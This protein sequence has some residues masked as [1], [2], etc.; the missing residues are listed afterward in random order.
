MRIIITEIEN[1]KNNI[2][3]NCNTNIG[4]LKGIWRGR[5]APFL[6]VVY[7]VEFAL[8]NVDCVNVLPENK[9]DISVS[10]KNDIIFFRG[11]CE[12]YDS[13]I[14][15]IRFAEDW[16]QMIYIEENSQV[17]NIGDNISFTL[18]YN[19]IEIFPYDI[20]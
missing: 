16:L 8:S 13:E 9:E 5:N 1:I 6:K 17:I 20:Y 2:I 11:I 12:D 15:Y 3:V 10:L 4:T 19:Q 7:Y 14:N 18:N